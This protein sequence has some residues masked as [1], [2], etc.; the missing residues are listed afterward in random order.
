MDLS[1][2]GFGKTIFFNVG[3]IEPYLLNSRIKKVWI[4]LEMDELIIH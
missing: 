3:Q 4:G 2:I 1:W